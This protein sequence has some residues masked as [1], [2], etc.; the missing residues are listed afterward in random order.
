M[1]QEIRRVDKVDGRLLL[2]V[3]VAFALEDLV[4]FHEL[5]ISPLEVIKPLPLQRLLCDL[6][7]LAA[8]GSLL[9]W[10]SQNTVDEMVCGRCLVGLIGRNFV[11]FGSILWSDIRLILRFI[12]HLL[13]LLILSSFIGLVFLVLAPGLFDH[14]FQLLLGL[15]QGLEGVG[16]TFVHIPF[17]GAEVLER[18]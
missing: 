6:H 5:V 17:V 3:L 9:G 15:D 10:L 11:I 14:S 1:L 4:G 2:L 7:D 12:M 8:F 16:I 13:D 18:H